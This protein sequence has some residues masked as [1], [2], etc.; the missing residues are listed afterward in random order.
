[1]PSFGEPVESREHVLLFGFGSER[2]A[3][4]TGSARCS[5]PVM[6]RLEGAGARQ[7]EI[8][9]LRGAEGRQFDPELVEM[10]CGDLFVEVLGQDVD[11]VLVFAVVREELDLRQHLV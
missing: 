9:G 2:C 8:V 3:I 1:M 11:L 7:G 5:I 6:L 10:Q 4:P